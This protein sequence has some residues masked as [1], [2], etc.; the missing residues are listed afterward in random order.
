MLFRHCVPH[1][2][3]PIFRN[4]FAKSNYLRLPCLSTYNKGIL[5][6]RIFD[7]F[8][9]TRYNI[10]ADALKIRLAIEN[11]TSAEE[12][13]KIEAFQ[14]GLTTL[15]QKWEIQNGATFNFTTSIV[16]S[17][18]FPLTT[19]ALTTPSNGSLIKCYF[20]YILLALIAQFLKHF[21]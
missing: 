3:N 5:P 18:P 11:T 9:H 12:Y 6:D 15:L 19:V 10:T 20:P 1:F 14:N 7:G 21:V 8:H 4:P 16:F 17:D 2:H 13:T